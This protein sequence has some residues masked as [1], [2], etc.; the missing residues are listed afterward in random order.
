MKI[1]FAGRYG[2]RVELL[3]YAAALNASGH[4]VT[5]RWLRGAH[6]SKDATPTEAEAAG[7]AKYDLEDIDTAD[8]VIA[9]TEAPDNPHGRGGRHVELGYAIAKDK[10]I[11]VVGHR[12]N[13]FCNLPEVLFFDSFSK[14]A[15]YI[16]SEDPIIA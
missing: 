4:A 12:E 5:S 16:N 3:K 7:W 11:F 10:R 13:I 9:F 14:L 2:R 15:F 6:E 1:Y 8:A